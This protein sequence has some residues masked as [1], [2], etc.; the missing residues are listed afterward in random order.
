MFCLWPLWIVAGVK[1]CEVQELDRKI[2]DAQREK[3]MLMMGGGAQVTTVQ[4]Q[5]VQQPQQPQVVI[6][7]PQQ[8]QVVVQTGQQPMC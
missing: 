1:Q 3:Q 4:H 2:Q 5:V 7:Q 6:Q 8:P